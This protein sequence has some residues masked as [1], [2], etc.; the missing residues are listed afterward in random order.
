MYNELLSKNLLAGIKAPTYY[1][2]KK[3]PLSKEEQA[4]LLRTTYRK[5]EEK[6]FVYLLKGKKY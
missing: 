6:L 2:K 5:S 3:N 4:K 1:A